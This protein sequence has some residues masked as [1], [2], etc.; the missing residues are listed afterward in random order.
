MQDI[1][2]QFIPVEVFYLEKRKFVF[3]WER[4]FDVKDLS[5]QINAKANLVD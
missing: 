5:N 1:D 3:E 2:H 4:K